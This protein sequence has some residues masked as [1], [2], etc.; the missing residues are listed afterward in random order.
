MTVLD[1]D[2]PPASA[3]RL[4]QNFEVL[5][6]HGGFG[7][8]LI[9]TT[10]ARPVTL[11]GTGP[12]MWDFFETPHTEPELVEWLAQRYQVAAAI[13]ARDVAPALV[14]LRDEGLLGYAP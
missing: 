1:A 6:R 4:V 10:G 3:G 5:T 9:A 7:L 11:R 2:R 13:V 12:D 8:V 14:K